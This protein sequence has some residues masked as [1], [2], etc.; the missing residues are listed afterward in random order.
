MYDYLPDEMINE[1]LKYSIF[2]D[3]NLY[4]WILCE[5]E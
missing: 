4:F 2:E 1:V 3:F 5:L